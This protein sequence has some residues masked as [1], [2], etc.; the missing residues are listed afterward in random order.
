MITATEEDY[1]KAIYSISSDTKQTLVGTNQIAGKLKTSAASVTDMLKKL[2][3]KKL[4]EYT[5]YKGVKLSA[6]GSNHAINLLRKH[7]LWES[8]LVLKLGMGWDEV[9]NLAE[10]L[11][12]IQSDILIDKL[13]IYLGH[14]KFDPHGEPIP[15][16]QGIFTSRNQDLLS[17]F[18]V[19]ECGIL[20]GVKKDD[21]KFLTHLN[22]FQIK[23]GTEFEV[24][25]KYEYDQSTKVLINQAKKITLSA[26]ITENLF[27]KKQTQ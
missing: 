12:H 8:F 19:A 4:I 10:Q 14:P 3:D 23:L 11:E 18:K 27:L 1:I 25:Q 24:L 17:S 20:I 9:H 2:K 15:D 26:E 16:Q 22:Q 21:I 5:K 7:R 6:T 13:D